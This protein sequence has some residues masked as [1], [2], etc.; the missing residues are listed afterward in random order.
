M[1]DQETDN[2]V[3]KVAEEHR[4]RV[5][6]QLKR[7]KKVKADQRLLQIPFTTL[8]DYLWV[9]RITCQLLRPFGP[10][11]MLYLAAAVSDFY[12]PAQDMSEH[13]MQ[14]SEVKC[15]K[16]SNSSQIIITLVFKSA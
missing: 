8:S 7:Y 14:S 1:L 2:G 16:S 5:Q 12:I 13:K 11:A 15:L 9:L 6:D 3:I 10:R 4:V